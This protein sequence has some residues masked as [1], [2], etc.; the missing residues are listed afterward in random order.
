MNVSSNVCAGPDALT[1]ST[2]GGRGAALRRLTPSSTSFPIVNPS[3]SRAYPRLTAPNRGKP[4]LSSSEFQQNAQNRAK[5]FSGG[6]RVSIRG[7]AT[8]CSSFRQLALTCAKKHFCRFVFIRVSRRTPRPFITASNAI[9]RHLTVSNAQN[10]HDPNTSP[11]TRNHTPALTL[12]PPVSD[13][14]PPTSDP[15]PPISDPG[16]AARRPQ[17]CSELFRPVQSCSDLNFIL[18]QA[19]VLR[20]SSPPSD[21]KS[22][23]VNRKSL[24]LNARSP[25]GAYCHLR[26]PIVPKCNLSKNPTS[27]P[28]PPISDRRPPRSRLAL[29]PCSQ[30][31]AIVGNCRLS[32]IRPETYTLNLNTRSAG[33]QTGTFLSLNTLESERGQPVR[34]RAAACLLTSDIRALTSAVCSLPYSAL[35]SPIQHCSA[36][37]KNIFFWNQIASGSRMPEN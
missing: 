27:D 6:S 12:R 14:R 2:G 34:F 22:N 29:T 23:I 7:Y 36:L 32:K 4:R 37:K 5:N 15:R 19:A 33:L 35:F 30:S 20:I 10:F 24:S 16:A 21:R 25:I 8:N 13:R 3:G 31:K 18:R 17:T 9:S 28:R 1:P 26:T 11:H